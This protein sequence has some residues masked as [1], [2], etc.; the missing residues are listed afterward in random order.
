MEIASSQDVRIYIPGS[1]WTARS[2]RGMREGWLVARSGATIC[3]AHPFST[4]YRPSSPPQGRVEAAQASYNEVRN[5]DDI[6][7]CKSH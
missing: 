3:V 6:P 2:E 4:F 1:T 7:Q 5:E